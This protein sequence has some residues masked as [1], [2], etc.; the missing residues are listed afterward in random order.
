MKI[1][2]SLAKTLIKS[3]YGGKIKK[4][5]QEKKVDEVFKNYSNTFLGKHFSK[6]FKAVIREISITNSVS[7]SAEWVNEIT[8]QG[9]RDLLSEIK[10]NKQGLRNYI[11]EQTGDNNA[12]AI[13]DPTKE[14]KE[15]I[16]SFVSKMDEIDL[17][18]ADKLNNLLKDSESFTDLYQE[19]YLLVQEEYQK[20]MM[21][22]M[23]EGQDIVFSYEP[24]QAKAAGA[25]IKKIDS[26]KSQFKTQN[27]FQSFHP[28]QFTPF[29]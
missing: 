21:K 16:D 29:F 25:I 20:Q 12:L 23:D 24:L 14:Q 6:Q 5:S 3:I 26:A 19:T 10:T 18:V 22:S 1:V 2:N 13:L 27:A 17:K 9:F 15:K 11:T 7:K 4:T 28:E 8:D